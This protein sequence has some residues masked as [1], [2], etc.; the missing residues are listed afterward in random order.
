MTI[1]LENTYIMLY[2]P[3]SDGEQ[4]QHAARCRVAPHAFTLL[5]N[6]SST[7][8]PTS[9]HVPERTSMGRRWR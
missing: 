3:A 7:L 2:R 5:P 8:I 6:I 1:A 9:P 4:I